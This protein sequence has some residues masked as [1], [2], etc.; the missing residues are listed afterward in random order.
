[1]TDRMARVMELIR[2]NDEWIKKKR[3]STYDPNS[4]NAR[5]GAEAEAR[6]L[7]ELRRFWPEWT[8]L[9]WHEARRDVVCMGPCDEPHPMVP[10]DNARNGDIYVYRR[11]TPWSELELLFSI[12]VK[13]S[14]RHSNVTIS[15]SELRGSSAEYLVADTRDGMWICKMDAARHAAV[16]H[17]SYYIIPRNKVSRTNFTQVQ[18]RYARR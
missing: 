5:L 13:S 15:D 7:Y 4:H 1:M 10:I 2:Q 12:E 9:P 18:D 6:V 11:R 14:E 8:V 3:T 16:W 17:D